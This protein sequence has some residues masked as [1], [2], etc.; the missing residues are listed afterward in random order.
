MAA[1][2]ASNH[3]IE[4]AFVAGLSLARELG[5]KVSELRA[6]TCL[7]QLHRRQS[8]SIETLRLLQLVCES[9]PEGF[10]TPDLLAAAAVLDESAR[11]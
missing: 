5:A 3:E 8:R 7:A 6:A 9:F 10:D 2:G 11:P 1:L 4:K